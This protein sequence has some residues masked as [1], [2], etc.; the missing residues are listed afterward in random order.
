[1]SKLLIEAGALRQLKHND[2]SEGFVAAYDKDITDEFIA[3]L[4]RERDELIEDNSILKAFGQDR[5]IAE[6][7]AKAVED[8][9]H[10]CAE[11]NKIDIVVADIYALEEDY[12]ASLRNHAGEEG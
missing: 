9:T 2:G 1:M 7:Q 6:L 5:D 4:Q 11:Q 12:T 3:K 8:F 10:Y